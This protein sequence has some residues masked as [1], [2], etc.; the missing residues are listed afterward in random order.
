MYII[1]VC[2]KTLETLWKKQEKATI[3][4]VVIVPMKTPCGEKIKKQTLCYVDIA[5]LKPIVRELLKQNSHREK[6]TM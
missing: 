1:N 4:N 5:S 2:A 3:Y 6:S